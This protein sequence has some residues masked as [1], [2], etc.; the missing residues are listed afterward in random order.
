MA[1]VG[2][3][4]HIGRG[5]YR[6]WHIRPVFFI[7]FNLDF[8]MKCVSSV[9]F[10]SDISSTVDSVFKLVLLKSTYLTNHL[11]GCNYFQIL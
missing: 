1:D 9:Y 6:A 8:P 7:E 4:A 3:G 10:I 2:Y 5:T 11:F